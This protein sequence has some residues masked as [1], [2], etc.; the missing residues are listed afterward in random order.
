MAL[1]K[2]IHALLR[3]GQASMYEDLL[4]EVFADM[5]NENDLFVGFIKAFLEI[6]LVNP[7]N[8][9]IDRVNWS[10]KLMIEYKGRL[11]FGLSDLI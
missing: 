4:T 3:K 8:V 5:F 7:Q 2:N 1:F 6:P 10:P 9:S 11:S